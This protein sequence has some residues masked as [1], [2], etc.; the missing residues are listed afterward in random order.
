MTLKSLTELAKRMTPIAESGDKEAMFVL[1]CILVGWS[2]TDEEWAR[3]YDLV[4][5][6]GHTSFDW[7][8][9]YASSRASA[10]SRA[11]RNMCVMSLHNNEHVKEMQGRE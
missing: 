5:R 10:Y 3:G 8:L 9:P 2:S 7:V 11:F 6:S 4:S 1:G